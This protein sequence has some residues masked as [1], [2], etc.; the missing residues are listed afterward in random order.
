[1]SDARQSHAGRALAAVQL[2]PTVCVQWAEPPPPPTKGQIWR[3]RWEHTASLVLVLEATRSTVRVAV[4]TAEPKLADDAAVVLAA[5]N[6]LLGAPLTVWDRIARNIPTC[7]LDRFV[8]TLAATALRAGVRASETVSPLDRR[9]EERARIEDMLGVLEMAAW[10]LP[11]EHSI[12][13]LL[14]QTGMRSSLLEIPGLDTQEALLIARGQRPVS[15]LLARSLA[16]L[17]D[18]P[19]SM[20]LQANPQLPMALVEELGQPA[21]RARIAALARTRGHDEP[22]EM[23]ATAYDLFALAARQTGV[24]QAPDW[25]QRLE[26]YLEGQGV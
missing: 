24:E 11:S 23:R 3:A 8:G 22:E 16:A 19:A 15:A 6:T 18:V 10:A 9:V 1:M 2:P 12:S 4:V 13:E 26:R 5:D 7:A 21:A 20:W 14:E 17:T 25:H